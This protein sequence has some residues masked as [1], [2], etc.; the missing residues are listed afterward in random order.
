MDIETL[1]EKM[2]EIETKSRDYSIA[3]DDLTNAI[4]DLFDDHG[5]VD[6][7]DIPKDLKAELK[8]FR[9]EHDPEL[10]NVGDRIQA[11]EHISG[12]IGQAEEADDDDEED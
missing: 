8:T 4:S 10:G 5:T 9:E 3:T 11:C 6:S 12:L 1:R 7:W 2:D